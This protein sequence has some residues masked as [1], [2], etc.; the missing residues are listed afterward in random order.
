MNHAPLHY[1]KRHLVALL[2]IA[3][4]CP[5]ATAG[6]LGYIGASTAEGTS[7]VGPSASYYSG[8]SDINARAAAR[9]D[10]RTQEAMSTLEKGRQLY[11]AGKYEEALTEYNRALDIL[12][13]APATDA[14]RSFIVISVGDASV[15]TAAQFMKV[16]RYDEARKLLDNALKIDPK[17]KLAMQQ[18]AYLEDPVRNNPAKTPQHMKNVEE[19]NRLLSMGFG[20]YDLGQYNQATAEFNK[21]LKIDPYNTAARRGQEKINLR[22]SMYYNA[23]YNQHRGELLA[24]VDAAWEAPI[25]QDIPEQSPTSSAPN[26][27]ALGAASNLNKLKTIII[28]AVKLDDATVEEA[29]DFLRKRS[30][31]LDSTPGP[32]GERGINFI[33]SNGDAGAT[34]APAPAPAVDDLGGEMDDAA[35]LDMPAAPVVQDARTRRIK[36]MDLKD[37]PMLEVL[38][39][40]CQQTGLSYKVEDYAVTLLPSD[41]SDGTISTR[42]FSVPPD[43]LTR[44][45]SGGDDASAG[46]DDP[47][48]DT[49]SAA[50]AR[51]SRG[52]IK[53]LLI[54]AGIPFP[55]GTSA[56]Y[57]QGSSTLIV[58]NT[59]TNLNYLEEMINDWNST[60]PTQI[61]ISTKFVEIV[62]ENTDELSFDWVVSPFTINKD[63]TTFLGGGTSSGSVP[64]RTLG[65]FVGAPN[66]QGAW[67]IKGGNP[68][69]EL[70]SGLVTGGNRTGSGAIG[71]SSIDNLLRNP[72]RTA[73]STSAAAPGIL[74]MTG[75]FD[76][77]TYQMIMRGLSQKKGSDVLTAP[78]V[79][80]KNGDRATIKIVREFIYPTEFEPP[81]LPQNVGNNGGNWD[82]GNNDNNEGG[83][84]QGNVQAFPVTPATPMAFEMKEVG[85]KLEVE[86]K[87]EMTD[88]IIDMQFEPEI[89]EFEGFVNY[90]S[91]IQTAGLD[92]EGNP[93]TLTLTENRMEQ[94][95]FSSR[96]VKTSLVIYDGHTVAI[97]GLITESVQTVEDKVPIFGD[98]PL[99]GRFFRSNADNHLK[100]NLMIFVTGQIID[101]TGNPL[102]RS[103][104][105]T[106]SAVDAT[107]AADASLLPPMP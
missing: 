103:T 16:G 89:I 77:G 50:P 25:P 73:S 107:S 93:I 97:G 31:A 43:I 84:G 96:S 19:V 86:P 23:A 99:V 48:G 6:D 26:D 41:G 18:L 35:A 91:P 34:P 4:T 9:R 5:I 24:A 46:S 52:P 63:G 57:N 42:K 92:G 87:A 71:T 49:A 102:R 81:Q 104:A 90:G 65:D 39:Y 28:P 75:V 7:M 22:R 67:P 32:N 64:D 8:T 44:L 36:S 2:T 68:N 101:P 105:A 45:S 15:A 27:I 47:F 10:E 94:P 61:R 56:T 37:M 53:E 55:D 60:L 1:S 20:Y 38:K 30:Q 79:T 12:P 70:G 69:N 58:R 80:V 51:K 82:N 74:S 17:N 13:K 62:Q 78:S 83:G 3:S 21:I 85:V 33:V 14:R 29:I 100:K 88:F 72:N 98:L 95:I 76:S 11:K 40:I 106:P 54:K 59:A 66:G